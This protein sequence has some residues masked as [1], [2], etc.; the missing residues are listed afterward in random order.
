MVLEYGPKYILFSF[1]EGSFEEKLSDYNSKLF[2]CVILVRSIW[3]SIFFGI[4][5]Y[6]SLWIWCLFQVIFLI[7]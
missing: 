2:S 6:D 5:V 7:N 3:F 1:A 4:M